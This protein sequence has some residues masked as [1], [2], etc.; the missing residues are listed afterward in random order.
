MRLHL[1][2]L[3]CCSSLCVMGAEAGP[4]VPMSF[5]GQPQLSMERGKPTA[6]GIRVVG[7]EQPKNEPQ[8]K[9]WIFDGSFMLRQTGY[10]S[11]K[12]YLTHPTESQA[13]DGQVT[14]PATLRSFWFRA[15]GSDATQPMNGRVVESAG[16][17]GA[18]LYASALLPT[19]RV[20]E[21]IMRGESIQI[22]VGLAQED[23]DRIFFGEVMLSDEDKRQLWKCIDDMGAARGSAGK[24]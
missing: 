13:L 10:G 5:T 11:L 9:I 22:G 17:V 6:C 15:S 19:L 1:V 12:G 14:P 23:F 18:K 2:T 8:N 7:I 21:A 3:A 16:T 24:K 4:L 20:H